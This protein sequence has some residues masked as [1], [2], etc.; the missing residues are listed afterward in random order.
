[1]KHIKYSLILLLVFF[2][3]A[4]AVF[5]GGGKRNGTAGASQLLIPVGARGIA[6]SG[7]TLTNSIGVESMFWNPANVARTQN[8]T[9]VMFSQTS[10]I[11]DIGVS[12]GA[13]VANIEGFGAIGA[14]IKS[15]SVG[16]IAKTT[17]D[18]PDGTGQTFTPQFVTVGVTYSRMLS[19]RISVG[20][21]TNFISEKI[22]FASASGV[23]F[24]IG[25]SYNNFANVNGLSI[26]V[27][28]KNIGSQMKY[29][30]SG[31][32]VNATAP[33]LSRPGQLYKIE[34]AAFELPSTL[35][36]GVGY[37][38]NF[39]KQNNLT[40]ATMFQ[41]NNFDGDMYKLGAEYSYNQLLYLRGGYTLAPELTDDENVYGFTLGGGLK[42]AVSGLDIRFDYAYQDTKYFD[43]NNVFT[44]SIGF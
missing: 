34:T 9:D 10:Y 35:E 26:A 18:N 44:L 28:M 7:S 27:V 11:A 16:E 29:D 43:G 22:D 20:L 8:S 21:T 2:L 33:D 38:Y 13:I 42:Y 31:L 4:D 14:S 1:M 12:Y 3:A 25:V 36:L 39:D 30:G 6:M 15:L 5:A 17:V 41:N 40:I 24:N 37:N 19:D 23:A 32:Y